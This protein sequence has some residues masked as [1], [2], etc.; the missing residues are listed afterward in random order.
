MLKSK[1]NN[2]TSNLV[3]TYSLFLVLLV[4]YLPELLIYTTSIYFINNVIDN[5]VY[6]FQDYNILI[7]SIR[8]I[9]YVE[10]TLQYSYLGT[11]LIRITFNYLTNWTVFKN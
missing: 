3:K 11:G 6:S 10:P 1:I 2:G 5:L 8:L 9:R 7:I 4:I